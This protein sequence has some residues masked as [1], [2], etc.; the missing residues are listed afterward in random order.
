MWEPAGLDVVLLDLDAGFLDHVAPDGEFALDLGGKLVGRAAASPRAPCEA[1]ILRTSGGLQR[2]RHRRM[3]P[4]QDL[5][6]RSGRR[7]ECRSKG[8]WHSPDTLSPITGTPASASA[9]LA[10]DTPIRRSRSLLAC[11][12]TADSVGIA[13]SRLPASRSVTAGAL[14]LYETLTMS[15]LLIWANSAIA[16]WVV[17]PVPAE[18]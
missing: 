1:S 3:E 4:V 6:R 5:L 12:S 13:S 16:R 10:V 15:V 8:R 14:P 18:P 11:G 2:L 7:Q 9:G 17:E